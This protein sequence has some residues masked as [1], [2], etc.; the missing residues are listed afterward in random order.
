M[1]EKKCF[2]RYFSKHCSSLRCNVESFVTNYSNK[3]II[4]RMDYIYLHVRL[5][6]MFNYASDELAKAVNCGCWKK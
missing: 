2:P 4:I 6:Y 5:T 1:E 3:L